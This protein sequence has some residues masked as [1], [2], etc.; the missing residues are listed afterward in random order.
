M[1]NGQN[2]PNQGNQK[3]GRQ[4][5]KHHD[6]LRHQVSPETVAGDKQHTSQDI[7]NGTAGQ[8]GST[9]KKLTP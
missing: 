3:H 6:K 5:Q 7:G 9:V 1:S 4:D 2:N 8:Q